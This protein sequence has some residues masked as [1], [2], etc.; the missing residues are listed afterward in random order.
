MGMGVFGSLS[1]LIVP[2][3]L[4]DRFARGSWGTAPLAEAANRAESYARNVLNP[5]HRE[6]WEVLAADLE[7]AVEAARSTNTKPIAT[8][9]WCQQLLASEQ[10]G[11][12]VL[13]NRASSQAL[14]QYLENSP[15]I[16]IG[17]QNR[18]SINT[19]SDLMAGRAKMDVVPTLFGGAVASSYA[20][21]LALP[22]AT[23]LTVMAHGPWESGRILRQIQNARS[24]LNHLVRGE[25]RQRAERILFSEYEPD[26]PPPISPPTIIVNESRALPLIPD[27]S[28]E[29]LWNPFDVKIARSFDRT[30]SELDVSTVLPHEIAGETVSALFL[31]FR[32]GS[33]FSCQAISSSRLRNGDIEDVAA[34][35]LVVGDSVVLVDRGAR[36]DLFDVIVDKLENLPEFETT[37]LL[38]REWHERARRAP[39]DSG[40][41][42]GDILARMGASTA[43]VS[44]QTINN[45]VYGVVHGPQQAEDIR[46]FGRAVNDTFLESRW[47]SIGRALS[48]IRS[49]RRK[50]GHMLGRVLGGIK[51][52]EL[53]DSG[54]FDRRLGIH[55]SDLTEALTVHELVQRDEEVTKVGWQYVNRLLTSEE[56]REIS[57]IRQQEE[58]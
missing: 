24:S 38:I 33:G 13:R 39:H 11:H 35:S 46:N 9:A 37:I 42:A 28:H 47:E 12:I 32:D 50:V 4:Y 51:P 40:L 44:S 36:R 17:W 26:P 16:P 52:T 5:D 27:S 21:L 1:H 2:I 19:F 31:Q 57:R 22:T 29:A 20:G 18:L 48:T 54:Y 23:R 41:S 49:H 3:E 15:D 45:W 55:Y 53:E 14:A 30:D 43:I 34:K 8:L 10:P 7:L 58:T 25:L 6:Y 56:D